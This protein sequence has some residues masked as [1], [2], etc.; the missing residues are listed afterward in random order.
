[1]TDS[2]GVRGEIEIK[3]TLK[4][5]DDLVRHINNATTTDVKAR[6]NAEGDGIELYDEAAGAGKIKVEDLSG[7]VAANLNIK[8]EAPGTGAANVI[9]GSFERT[10][11]FA[12]TDGLTQIAQKI[13]AANVGVI[14]SVIN[15]GSGSAPFRLS[16]TAR[17]TGTSGRMIVDSGGFELGLNTLDQGQDARVFFGASDPARAV[18]LTSSRNTLDSVITGVTIDLASTSSE[19]VTLTVSRDTAAIETAVNVFL[20]SFNAL[21]DR[22]AAQTK[23]DKDTNTRGTLLGDSTALSLRGVLYST[24]NGRAQGLDGA[25]DRL[26]D[27]GITVGEGGKLKLDRDR[28][29]QAMEQDFQSVADL[30]STRELKPREPIELGTGITVNNPDAPDEFL[31]LGVP[32]QLEHLANGYINT[33]DGVLTRRGRSL[34]D[35]I[36]LQTKRI[37]DI[38]ARLATRRG[39]L[40][41]QFLA[42]EQAIGKLQAQQSSLGQISMLG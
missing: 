15:D 35:Q 2:M 28:L 1:V 33:V 39:I 13:S 10:L 8:G 36:D 41:R 19:P 5:V 34:T 27:V 32:G 22:I 42:M 12:A 18:L 38:D 23:Y 9:D 16:L 17:A 25:F 3:D 30:F 4:T 6:I 37:A 21:A 14:A 24:A 7:V 29:R 40:E 31:K 20:D 26:V 11:T